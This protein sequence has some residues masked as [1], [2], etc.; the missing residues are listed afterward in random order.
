MGSVDTAVDLANPVINAPYDPPAQHFELAPNDTP[1]GTLLPGRR[2]SES[3][4]PVP[5]SRK[6]KKPQQALTFEDTG[7]RREVNTLVNDI[8][9]VVELWRIRGYPDASPIS[10]KLMQHWADPT[11][12]NR[13]LFCVYRGLPEHGGLE[14][15]L[16]LDRRVRHHRPR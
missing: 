3:F 2:A 8:R 1:T 14:V 12:E 4:I 9:Q 6:A 5:V 7:E 10:R 11:R 15:G 16:R 13:V